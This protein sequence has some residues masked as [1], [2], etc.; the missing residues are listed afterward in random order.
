MTIYFDHTF[1]ALLWLS[2]Y[3]LSTISVQSYL[4]NNGALKVCSNTMTI[5]FDH[6]FRAVLW[7][8]QYYLSTATE[9]IS[10]CYP[11]TISVPSQYHLSTISVQPYLWN[12]GALKVCSNTMTI[13]F[14]H[15]FRAVLW[16]S[17]YHLSTISV[18]P[19]KWYLSAIPVLSQCYPS[20]ISVPSQ[21]YLSTAILVK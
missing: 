9:M 13:Y 19:V 17:Q 2:Q 14:D 4:W 20:T 6:T 12:N 1:R 10:Q 11:S 7:L 16:L 3:H 5:Y 18:L 21:Y 15:T 8:S